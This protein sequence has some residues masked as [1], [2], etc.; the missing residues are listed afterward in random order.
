MRGVREI[1]VAGPAAPEIA[2]I[3]DLAGK[4]IY[5]RKTSSYYE[6]LVALNEKF[7]A[8]GLAVIKLVPA[9]ENLEE[10]T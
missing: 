5:V 1:L 4:D 2:K 6:H 10:R 8:R 9:D 3:E 7:A